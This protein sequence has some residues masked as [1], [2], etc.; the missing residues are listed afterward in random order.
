M[1][2]PQTWPD[3]ELLV[4]EWLTAGLPGTHI[5]TDVP[6]SSVTR[7]VRVQ[8]VGG[9]RSQVLDQARIL[10]ETRAA[11]RGDC[12]DLANDVRDLVRR[13]PGAHDEGV[14]SGVEEVGGPAWLPD[15]LTG[16]PRFASTVTVL[17]KPAD[18]VPSA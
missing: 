18:V 10:L 5:G 14:V 7:S 16:Q 13:L 8:R 3:V 15:P 17:A 9:P 11:D 2:G 4:I 1:R 6:A 12:L